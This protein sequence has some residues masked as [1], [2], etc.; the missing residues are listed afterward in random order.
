MVRAC[1]AR[2]SPSA[3]APDAAA[4]A[5]SGRPAP[6]TPVIGCVS[7]SR[8]SLTG[9][10]VGVQAGGDGDDDGALGEPVDDRRGPGAARVVARRAASA[11]RRATG[12][13]AARVERRRGV[14]GQREQVRP[15]ADGERQVEV[16]RVV[17]R[18]EGARRQEGQVLAVERE[19]R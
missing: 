14:G 10:Q 2:R 4:S 18:V 5:P 8:P 7:H 16:V 11:A 6:I 17:D 19:R 1:A 13:P 15:H 12:R 9:A 3:T